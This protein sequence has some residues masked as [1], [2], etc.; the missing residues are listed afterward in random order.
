MQLVLKWFIKTKRDFK[1]CIIFLLLTTSFSFCSRVTTKPDRQAA[2]SGT[3]GSV[4]ANERPARLPV[5][6]TRIVD[7]SHL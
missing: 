7:T 2:T 1:K 3:M 4:K 6:S 5:D